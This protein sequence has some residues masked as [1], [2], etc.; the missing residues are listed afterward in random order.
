MSKC[1][2]ELEHLEQL[3]RLSP[4][5]KA[6]EQ[7][8]E[9]LGRLALGVQVRPAMWLGGQRGSKLSGCESAAFPHQEAT[10]E[11]CLPMLGTK[12]GRSGS[13]GQPLWENCDPRI[14]LACHGPGCLVC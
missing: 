1:H 2:E 13:E 12:Y 5:K 14:P 4:A 8:Q 3:E 11:P 10:E 7:E 6:A 9:P